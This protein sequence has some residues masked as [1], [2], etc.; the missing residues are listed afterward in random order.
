[1]PSLLIKR[2]DGNWGPSSDILIKPIVNINMNKIYIQTY[3]GDSGSIQYRLRIRDESTKQIVF[4]IEDSEINTS[5]RNPT[6]GNQIWK[7]FKDVLMF[8]GRTYR[9]NIT[10]ITANSGNTDYGVW[11]DTTPFSEES[12]EHLSVLQDKNR[13]FG[14][15]TGINFPE[16]RFDYTV[17]RTYTYPNLPDVLIENDVIVFNYTG[18]VQSFSRSEI[19]KVNI[20]A[21]GAAG[22]KNGSVTN[23]AAKG[24]LAAG[25]YTVPANTTFHVYV[26]GKGE[27]GSSNSSS[28]SRAQGGW[29]GGGGGG[30]DSSSYKSG[31]AGAGGGASDV[32]VGGRELSNRII[33][34]GGA[35]GAV[36]GRNGQSHGG[37]NGVDGIATG[38]PGRGGKGGT[39]SSGGT[40][41]GYRGAQDGNLGSGGNGSNWYNAYGGGGGGGG[42]YGGGGGCSTQDH[43]QGHAGEGG[44]GSSYVSSLLGASYYATG[45][46][47]GNGQVIFTILEA[48]D[49]NSPPTKPESFVKQPVAGSVNLSG[50]SI[51][52]EW[53]ASTDPEGDAISYKVE[54]FN[55]S[56]WIPVASN[57]VTTSYSTILPTLDTDKA[58]FRVKAVDSKAGQSDYTVG[59]IFTI[60]TRLLLVQDNNIVKSFKDGVWIAI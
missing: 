28:S 54:L 21:Y 29:N 53:M 8:A 10:T 25:V 46:R 35:G 45:V 43:G 24:G 39:Q 22:G 58:Q 2:A 36:S 3:N 33:V 51:I 44:G 14:S 48:K 38:S 27:D 7:S 12:N 17:G 19:K 5:N 30:R 23:T 57:I 9:L 49:P 13:M 40:G 31:N 47:E 34:G 18:D 52:L 50:E 15:S 56:S 37:Y 60:A 1:M 16:I 6:V 55:G 26:G 4:D 20:M 42:Y 59:N 41:G 11:G 32:R